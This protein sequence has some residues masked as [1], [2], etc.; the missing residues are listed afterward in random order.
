MKFRHGDAGRGSVESGEKSPRQVARGIWPE[1]QKQFIYNQAG[2]SSA[3][4]G[5][6]A[7][8]LELLAE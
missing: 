6:G 2:L 4:C 5:D 7:Q 1:V 3:G 8:V